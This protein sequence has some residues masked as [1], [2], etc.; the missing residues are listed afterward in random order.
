MDKSD[1][2]LPA[3]D[4]HLPGLQTMEEYTTTTAPSNAY[5]F[6]S[7]LSKKLRDIKQ[8]PGMEGP[9]LTQVLCLIEDCLKLIFKKCD[10]MEFM[11]KRIEDIEDFI[12]ELE[13]EDRYEANIDEADS[14]DIEAELH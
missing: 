4:K 12:L 1:F 7:V 5:P 2:A 3:S 8:T 13:K 14:Q 6:M 10:D 9:R 11:N